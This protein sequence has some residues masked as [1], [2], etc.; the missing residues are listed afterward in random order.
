MKQ[1]SVL[2]VDGNVAD[3]TGL[4]K[5]GS[6]NNV[7]LS[8]EF[9]V[10]LSSE[11]FAIS[12]VNSGTVTAG[13]ATIN[14]VGVH[15]INSSTTANSGVGIRSSSTLVRLKG[16]EIFTYIFNPQ[17]FTNTTYKIIICN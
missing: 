17:T 3:E 4:V 1:Y 2:S 5:S 14:N 6:E 12:A 9:L 16:N 15:R 10:N 11:D 7:Y 13:T 8:H